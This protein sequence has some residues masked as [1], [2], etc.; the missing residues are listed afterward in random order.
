MRLREVVASG[1]FATERLWT[2]L[3]T[4]QSWLVRAAEVLANEEKADAARVEGKYR[5]LLEEVLTA[6]SD[7]AVAA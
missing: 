2:P 5:E 6:K 1:L 4:A 7:E 3:K